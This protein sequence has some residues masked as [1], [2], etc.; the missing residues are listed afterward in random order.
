M[1]RES[2]KCAID[3]ACERLDVPQSVQMAAYLFI[4]SLTHTLIHLWFI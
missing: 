3:Q 1:V 4:Y 2:Y